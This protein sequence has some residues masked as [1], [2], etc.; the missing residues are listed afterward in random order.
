MCGIVGWV[1]QDAE[2]RAA[3]VERARDLMAH[4]GPDDAGLWSGGRA[5]LG[6]RRLSI[7]DLTAAGHQPMLSADGQVALVF[8]GEIY[9]FV[10]LRR[11]LEPAFAFQSH[12]DSEVLIHGYQA[13]GW[14]GLLDRIDGMFAIGVWDAHRG[15]L[16]LARDRVGKKPLY[17]A[18]TPDGLAFASTLLALRALTPLDAVDTHAV[19]AYL[20]YQAVPAPLTFFDGA[21]SL[22]AA[23]QAVFDVAGCRLT[24]ARY[25]D[26]AVRPRLVMPEADAVDA[27]DRLVHAAVQRRLVADVPVGAFLSG[28]VDS[29]LVT[30]VMAQ[31]GS[32]EAFTL[33]FAEP[34]ID[35]R[36]YARAVARRWGLDLHEHV[37]GAEQVV[38]EL[39]RMLWHFGQPHGDVSV[40]P[41]Y[42]IAEAARRDVTVVLN[43]DGGDEVFAGYARP[44][45]AR[46]ARLYRAAL[47]A[48]LRLTLAEMTHRVPG[49]RLGKVAL[50]VEAGRGQAI[51]NAVYSRGLRA[52]RESA[53]T[54]ALASGT[55]NWQPD[56][57]NRVAWSRLAEADEIDRALY[58]DLTTYLPDQLLTKMDTATMAHGLEARSPLL[59][60]TIVEFGMRLDPALRTRHFRTKYLLKRL[61]ERYVPH[62]SIYRRKQGFVMPVDSWMRGHL[63]PYVRAG[64]TSRVFAEREWL[65]PEFVRGLLDQ[66]VEPDRT[67]GQILWTVFVLAIWAAFLDGS[68]RPD[69]SLEALLDLPRAAD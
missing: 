66:S 23:H 29:G 26:V 35:E 25:W 38:R 32:V 27:L 67:S 57:M 51:D 58:L 4:R 45:I 19:D 9:N 13:W 54:A 21:R 20:V 33:G 50:L 46:A 31:A 6:S 59:D 22:P 39:P 53:Y 42:A 17:Y 12:G 14:H 48:S 5:C 62:E 40:V 37:L 60:R 61:A 55:Y 49:G 7:L 28:G 68:L 65:R 18:E 41:T 3:S 10:D 1:G 2:G 56:E 44:V 8:N 11:Q 47:P 43:G 15:L 30:A 36:R 34:A 16:H 52:V 63:N 69:D 24:V 64:L